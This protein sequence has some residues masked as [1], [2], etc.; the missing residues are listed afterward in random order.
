ML[1]FLPAGKDE[2]HEARGEAREVM[3]PDGAKLR[4]EQSGQT[5]GPTLILTY[6]WGLNSTAWS[7]TK[8]QLG[9]DSS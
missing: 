8:R 9:I 2:S 4:V 1:M 3:A 7:Y 5:G 6:G